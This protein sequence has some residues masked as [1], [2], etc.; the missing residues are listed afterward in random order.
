MSSIAGQTDADPVVRV[1]IYFTDEGP[2]E[3]GT[4]AADDLAVLQEIWASEDG[5]RDADGDSITV[6]VNDIPVA[7]SV[8]DIEKYGLLNPLSEGSFERWQA[9]EQIHGA[10]QQEG[11]LSTDDDTGK[12]DDPAR[13]RSGFALPRPGR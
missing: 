5:F 2:P 4:D 8:E 3:S 1:R 11:E 10:F 7:E 9:K 13:C 12:N 6:G